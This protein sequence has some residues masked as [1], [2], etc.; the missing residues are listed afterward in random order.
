VARWPTG[1]RMLKVY[2]QLSTPGQSLS[3]SAVSQ[4]SAWVVNIQGIRRRGIGRKGNVQR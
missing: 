2:K 1:G 3:D 4:Q